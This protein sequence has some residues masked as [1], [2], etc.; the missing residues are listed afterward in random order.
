MSQSQPSE[1]DSFSPLV[2]GQIQKSHSIPKKHFLQRF[3]LLP[4]LN[5]ALQTKDGTKD[6][7]HK[8]NPAFIPAKIIADLKDVAEPN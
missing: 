7:K 8:Y 3:S 1:G 2:P 6:S 5:G 4:D